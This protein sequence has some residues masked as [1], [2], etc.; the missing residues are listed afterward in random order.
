MVK[1]AVLGFPRIGGERQMKKAVEGYWSGKVTESEMLAV[2]QETKL[3]SWKT[4][5]DAG[6]DFIPSGDFTLY[7]HIL[8]HACAFG[9]VP[10]RFTRHQNLSE[11]D[12]HFAM[13]R[14]RQVE[15]EGIDE[16][17]CEMRKWFDSN[18]HYVVVSSFLY[19]R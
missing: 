6:V 1:S 12:T 11:L 9:V 7:D 14:G 4:M 16:P 18:Y 3:A 19:L 15:S 13:A 17:A 10:R 8:D 2:A 5:A